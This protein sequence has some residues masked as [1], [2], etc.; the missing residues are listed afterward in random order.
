MLFNC[1]LLGAL[2]C[3]A[4]A[5]PVIALISFRTGYTAGKA[6]REDR[7]I[8]PVAPLPKIKEKPEG[9]TPQ[10]ERTNVIL[11]NID[12]YDGTRKGQVKI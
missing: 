8:L 3:Q 10:Q 6:V 1:I 5:I 12:A 4:L 2:M 9:L 7:E 11:K